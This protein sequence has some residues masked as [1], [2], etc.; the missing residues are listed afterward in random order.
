MQRPP[1]ARPQRHSPEGARI[2]VY[3]KTRSFLSLFADT[4][5]F[6]SCKSRGEFAHGRW[7]GAQLLSAAASL[8]RC[9]CRAAYARYAAFDIVDDR[10]GG[11][12]RIGHH[13]RLCQCAGAWIIRQPAAIAFKWG[14]VIA[15]EAEPDR[16]P[17]TSAA[18]CEHRGDCCPPQPGLP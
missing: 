11:G 12:E 17:P 1:S 7:P 16:A 8:R 15:Q 13:H 9:V 18:V 2:R 14:L 4:L 10:R 6:L 3:R 5:F